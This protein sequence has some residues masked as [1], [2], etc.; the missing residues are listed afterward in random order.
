ME[1]I[2]NDVNTYFLMENKIKDYIKKNQLDD[3]AKYL[4]FETHIVAN[5]QTYRM[6]EIELYICNDKHKDIFTHCHKEQK[7]MLTWYFHQMS[8][9]EHSYKGGTFKGLDITCGGGT[10][11]TD[12][13]GGVLIRA[14]MNENT[15]EVIEGPCNVVNELLKQTKCNSIKELVIEKFNN[16]LS[17]I[18]HNL[19][20]V[21][22]KHYDA[23]DIYVAPR[24]GLSMK[25]TN[26][27]EKEEYVDRNYRY[28]IFKDR[29]KKEKKKME[30]L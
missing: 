12:N 21:E 8:D 11:S 30:K 5:D 1:N 6:I 22:E 4:L 10:N 3:L 20:K 29:I 16:N 2:I 14:V 17:C 27:D 9:K 25:G 13:Y 26:V 7:N 19:L 15:N 18:E 24:I 23:S 28:I